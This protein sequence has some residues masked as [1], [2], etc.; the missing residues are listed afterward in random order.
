MNKCFALTWHPRVSAHTKSYSPIRVK[1]W[2]ELG[3]QLR[4]RLIQPK[5]VWKIMTELE[6]ETAKC[7]LSNVGL[8]K[9]EL[10][11]IVKVLDP[12]KVD[13]SKYPFAKRST[14]FIIRT[15]SECFMFETL[16]Q[17]EKDKIIAGLKLT[18][19]RL[20]SKIVMEDESILDE[21]FSPFANVDPG[22]PPPVLGGKH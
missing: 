6:L 15:T 12:N 22:R 19:A 5:L 18:I 11:D 21:F 17:V 8:R 4:S 9:V 13:R 16:S 1:A 2:I 7:S 10:L 20:G 14:S 3:T